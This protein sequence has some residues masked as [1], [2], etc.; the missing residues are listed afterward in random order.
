MSR[1]HHLNC[2]E[3][4]AAFAAALAKSKKARLVTSDHEFKAVEKKSKSTG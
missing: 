1:S 2:R 3:R 4:A